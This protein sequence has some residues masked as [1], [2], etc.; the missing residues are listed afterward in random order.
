M[1]NNE[2]L[3]ELLSKICTGSAILF[4][5]AGFSKGAKNCDPNITEVP[6]GKQ[7]VE[8]I[9]NIGEFEEDYKNAKLDECMEYFNHRANIDNSLM[10]KLIDKFKN[11]FTISNFNDT[12]ENIVMLP[13]W[14]R[15]WTTNYDN[16][17]EKIANDNKLRIDPITLDDRIEVGKLQCI[18][19]N[20][21]IHDLKE[22]N[23][24]T[25]FK[26]SES[27]YIKQSNVFINSH[28]GYHFNRDLNH[29]TAIVFVGY[30]LADFE[31][32]TLLHNAPNLKDKTYFIR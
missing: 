16:L 22:E 9:Q 17:V 13:K 5:G 18:H 8:I 6:D 23:I 28:L 20:G 27:S 12:Q 25:K 15:I 29:S 31:I 32:K 10:P 14:K 7:L 1:D 30:S 11:I 24:D 3:N 19:I 4:L 2:I 21:Y 26:I